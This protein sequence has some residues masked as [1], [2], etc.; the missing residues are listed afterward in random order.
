M[1]AQDLFNRVYAVVFEK[2][3]DHGDAAN[4]AL[5]AVTQFSKEWGEGTLAHSIMVGLSAVLAGVD[6]ER[7]VDGGG[8]EFA[9]RV[10]AWRTYAAAAI[11]AGQS[12]ETAAQMAR[13]MVK[14][15][16]AYF[17]DEW[18]EEED[19]RRKHLEVLKEARRQA[20]GTR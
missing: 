17:C 1:N 18:R 16:Q 3:S 8:E 5:E 19:R 4:E 9:A 20:A 2:T 6:I 14:R 10:Y 12:A 15:E 13:D 11:S 7:M